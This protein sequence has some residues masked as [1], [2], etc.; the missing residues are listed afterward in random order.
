[1]RSQA[2]REGLRKRRTGTRQRRAC[3]S[4]QEILN[5]ARNAEYAA[6]WSMAGSLRF[7]FFT[8]DKAPL[9]CWKRGIQQHTG[10]FTSIAC[11]LH[12]RFS[13]NLRCVTTLK[14]AAC[15]SRELCLKNMC[16]NRIDKHLSQPS[17][18]LLLRVLTEEDQLNEKWRQS[19]SCL[20]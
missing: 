6:R 2:D 16:I 18:E 4:T 17:F 15:R 11:L 1:M 3:F 19:A 7:V 9:S 13:K 20:P 8:C 10:L 5:M 14:T 12:S